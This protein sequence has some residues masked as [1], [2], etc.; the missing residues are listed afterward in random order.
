MRLAVDDD[1]WRCD[2]CKS[3][4]FPEKNDDGVSVLGVASDMACPI[5]VIPLQ[6][7]ALA[8][9]RILYCTRCRGML[10]SMDVFMP[11][12][13]ELR[14]GLAGTLIAH[15]PDPHDLERKIDCPRCHQRMDT[16]FYA[17]PGNVI[18]DDCSQCLL[19]WLDHGELMRVV[20][21]LDYIHV[22]AED[23]V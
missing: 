7:A 15:T 13:E 23:M 8:K 5:C 16:H 12:V 14:A 17:G 19:N 6:D 11:L 10:V 9:L 4:F 3:V 20:R 21:A 22:R 18:I 1:C 2:Y